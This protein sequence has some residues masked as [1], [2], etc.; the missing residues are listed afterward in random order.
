MTE[1]N[2]LAAIERV[3]AHD[4]AATPGPWRH[5]SNEA[6]R[7]RGEAMAVWQSGLHVHQERTMTTPAELLAL[8]RRMQRRGRSDPGWLNPDEENAVATAL[9]ALLPLAPLLD[10]EFEIKAEM[11]NFPG[12]RLGCDS[13]PEP[14]PKR[15]GLCRIKAAWQTARA[16]LAELETKP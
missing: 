15:C 6:R 11:V 7:R 10:E 5:E 2:I 16:K 1:Q 13:H 8:C 9:A 4:Q 14:Y 12:E 3:E